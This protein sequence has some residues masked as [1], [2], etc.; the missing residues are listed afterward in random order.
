LAFWTKIVAPLAN[1]AMLFIA[2]PFAFSQQRSISTGQ[3]LVIG[4][5]IG[6]LFYLFN[7]LLGNVVLLYGLPPLLGACLPMLVLYSIGFWAL[8][9]VR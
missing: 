5:L 6:L 4:I 2:M 3:R 9:R 7:R 1:L 8:S